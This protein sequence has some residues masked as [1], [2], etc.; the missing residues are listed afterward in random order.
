MVLTLLALLLIMLILLAC[1]WAT[2]KK[3][4]SNKWRLACLGSVF[5]MSV[6]PLTLAVFLLFCLFFNSLP[7]QIQISNPSIEYT[8]RIVSEGSRKAV[9]HLMRIDLSKVKVWVSP[10]IS[11]DR[12]SAYKAMTTSQALE[13]YEADV[14]IN[15]SFF[16]PFKDNHLLDFY[17]HSGQAVYPLGDTYYNNR[18]FGRFG[19]SWPSLIVLNDKK[20]RIIGKSTVPKL[21]SK[22]EFGISGRQL[23]V[24]NATVSRVAKD[25]FYA[26]TVVGLNS[27]N[28]VLWLAVVDG[29]QPN[30]SDGIRLTTLAAELIKLGVHTAIELDGGGSSTMAVKQKNKSALVL[31]RPIHTNIP[32]RERP[33]VN[34][35]LIRLLP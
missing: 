10:P 16:I 21:Q 9:V 7:N 22:I 13:R 5:A 6:A 28:T 17:P 26:R 33:V 18:L 8:N 30:Y 11:T 29:K 12:Q 20:V 35:L 15:G 4:N 31:N 32:Y 2:H 27:K 25:S 24:E 1:A 19:E 23:I 34:H 14:A 3:I